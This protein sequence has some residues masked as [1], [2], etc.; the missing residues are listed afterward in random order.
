MSFTESTPFFLNGAVHLHRKGVNLMA[1]EIL[2]N[3]SRMS[4]REDLLEMGHELI[5][6]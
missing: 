1:A 3:L 4:G 6:G 5:V 2:Q